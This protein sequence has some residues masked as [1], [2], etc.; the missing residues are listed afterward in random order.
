MPRHISIPRG[1]VSR[2]SRKNTLGRYFEELFSGSADSA[3]ATLELPEEATASFNF[4]E[5]VKAL[6]KE[7]SVEGIGHFGW[8]VPHVWGE[9][10]YSVFQWTVKAQTE[11]KN[12]M[13]HSGEELLYCASGQVKYHFYW[14]FET[15]TQ[16]RRDTERI[17]ECDVP[18][19]RLVRVLPNVPHHNTSPSGDSSG[20]MV[21]R[22]RSG[23]TAPIDEIETEA[24]RHLA[25]PDDAKGGLKAIGSGSFSVDSLSDPTRAGLL[26]LDIPGKLR[27]ARMRSGYSVAQLAEECDI[28]PSYIWRLEKGDTNVSSHTLKTIAG[29]VRLDLSD[30]NFPKYFKPADDSDLIFPYQPQSVKAGEISHSRLVRSRPLLEKIPASDHW[31]HPHIYELDTGAELFHT[32]DR[33]QI[34][35]ATK[36]GLACMNTDFGPDGKCTWIVLRGELTFKN[37]TKTKQV[38]ETGPITAKPHTVMHMRSGAEGIMKATE[39]SVL[40]LFEFSAICSCFDSSMAKPELHHLAK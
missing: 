3:S 7:G 11:L 4:P 31:L 9:P 12:L 22:H 38:L 19:G 8:P 15:R 23:S 1:S 6:R 36:E 35:R 10:S 13:S 16:P 37:P 20:W 33:E 25:T 28:H 5:P 40:L 30:L 14:P 39:N 27:V 21:I 18:A 24:N 34:A 17:V 32:G 29:L 2:G 26:L